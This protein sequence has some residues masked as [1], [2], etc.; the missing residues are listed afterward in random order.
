MVTV[1]S[2]LSALSWGMKPGFIIM[3]Q[4]LKYN[5]WNGDTSPANKMLK[6]E[7]SA[8]KTYADI[9]LGYEWINSRIVSGGRRDDQQCKVQHHAGR[10]TEA[11]NSQ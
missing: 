7:T 8:G 11:C 5:P 3:N 10:E 9:V 1:K 6:L 2:F 4:N